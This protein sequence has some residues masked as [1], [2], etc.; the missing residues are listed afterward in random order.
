MIA[1]G[2]Q[3]DNMKNNEMANYSTLP[4]LDFK[5]SP[6]MRKGTVN[7]DVMHKTTGGKTPN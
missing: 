4:V 5:T 7:H 3:F 6:F 1:G 2:V